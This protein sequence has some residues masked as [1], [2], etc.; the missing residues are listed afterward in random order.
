MEDPPPAEDVTPR[1]PNVGQSWPAILSG[2]VQARCREA[3]IAA[4]FVAP[5]RDID[6]LIGWWLVGDRAQE[7]DVPL[8]QGWRRELVGQDL[9]DWLHGRT[10]VVVDPDSEAGLTIRR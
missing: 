9:M 5:R 10:A 6:E 7:P 2:I 4:R 3:S 1:V 8:L